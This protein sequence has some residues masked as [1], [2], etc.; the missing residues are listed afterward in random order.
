MAITST[1]QS[2]EQFKQAGASDFMAGLGAV[3][4]MLG[5]WKLMTTDYFRNY[6]LGD[7]LERNTLLPGVKGAADEFANVFNYK[8]AQLPKKKAAEFINKVA[9]Y[10]TKEGVVQGAL[11]ES[12]EEVM[13]E[14]VADMIKGVSLALNKLGLADSNKT[15]DFGF[16]GK[17][18]LSRYGTAFVGG[19]IG[20]AVFSTH[21]IVERRLSGKTDDITPSGISDLVFYLRRGEGDKL[22]K[23]AKE[24]RDKGKLGSTSLSTE[25]LK[26]ENNN[27]E[28]QVVYKPATSP[29]TSQNEAV[30]KYLLDRF[31]TIETL[32]RKE[33]LLVTDTF[34]KALVSNPDFDFDQLGQEELKAQAQLFAEESMENALQGGL[35]S[36]VVN[37]F[38]SIAEKLVATELKMRRLLTPAV[39]ES[40]DNKAIETK[41]ESVK[42]SSEYIELEDELK[43][44]REKRDEILTGKRN[45]YYLEQGLFVGSYDFA[46]M[47]N[48]PLNVKSY[49]K[50]NY[51]KNYDDLS[52][53][54]KK[55]LDE[56]F[57]V[58]LN[59]EGKESI[60][61][62]FELFRNLSAK[63]KEL[64][65]KQGSRFESF[66]EYFRGSELFGANW[67]VYRQDLLSAKEHA[68]KQSKE[69]PEELRA[70]Y[71]AQ[72]DDINE[73]L[74]KYPESL[75]FAPIYNVTRITKNIVQV[76]TKN[77][78]E[79]DAQFIT[80]LNTYLDEVSAYVSSIKKADGFIESGDLTIEALFDALHQFAE[81][82]PGIKSELDV[83]NEYYVQRR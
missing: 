46:H 49:T 77:N 67:K 72:V 38:Q 9:N 47:F 48:I 66:R 73:S 36:R 18:F 26:V 60:Y 8:T 64:V 13:E 70:G 20:G 78:G 57:R 55:S 37:D 11:N 29:E 74:S 59:K 4:T 41:I 56:E 68:E 12:V 81:I 53:D 27:G 75:V 50:L 62:A 19:A 1:T 69:G 34:L 51:D 82:N 21:D 14:G 83:V 6:A 10:V 28:E 25:I 39:D 42:K 79:T 44:L 2:Y 16:S 35:A 23:I 63:T 32:L 40:S 33:N 24:L 22:R 58:Y 65:E 3:G 31:D 71:Q 45:G 76:P 15:Y 80:R 7:E 61:Y 43:T 17:D 52:D 54:K 30:Y 5:T